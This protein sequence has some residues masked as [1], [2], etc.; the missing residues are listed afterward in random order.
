MQAKVKLQIG[1]NEESW[2]EIPYNFKT[3]LLY[4]VRQNETVDDILRMTR[5]NV[6]EVLRGR[7][8]KPCDESILNSNAKIKWRL[9]HAKMKFN[10]PFSI[11]A[12]II[13][14]IFE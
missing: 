12:N 5:K 13:D 3:C 1:K 6:F 10:I 7:I 14:K 11:K 9:F 4:A 8:W 2:V